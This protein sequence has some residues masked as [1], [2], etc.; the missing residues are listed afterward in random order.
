MQ[1]SA[2]LLVRRAL[3]LNFKC[4]Q[5]K[6]EKKLYL[7][8]KNTVFMYP[9]SPWALT[10]GETQSITISPISS[11][12]ETPENRPATKS[13]VSWSFTTALVAYAIFCST[14]FI[15]YYTSEYAQMNVGTAQNKICIGHKLTNACTLNNNHTQSSQ[16]IL[17]HVQNLNISLYEWPTVQRKNVIICP[18]W[19]RWGL[20]LAIAFRL[21]CDEKFFVKI[22]STLAIIL[23][24]CN[25][26]KWDVRQVRSWNQFL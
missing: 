5:F 22:S 16:C 12:I 14:Q 13:K 3:N 8:T 24:T 7:N 4:S 21:S 11:K 1:W 2:R 6:C 19:L 23:V 20:N 9:T 18:E 17:L 10:F 26:T 25:I 15:H